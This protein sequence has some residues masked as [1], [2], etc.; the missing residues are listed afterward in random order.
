M[1]EEI[2]T[3]EMPLVPIGELGYE[4]VWEDWAEEITDRLN[5]ALST[6]KELVN[7]RGEKRKEG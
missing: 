5:K 6:I 1:S 3:V 4:G 7:S 2:N